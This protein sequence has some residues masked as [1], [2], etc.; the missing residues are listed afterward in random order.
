MAR[1]VSS[2]GDTAVIVGA[3]SGAFTGAAIAP[4]ELFN[5][6]ALYGKIPLLTTTALRLTLVRFVVGMVGF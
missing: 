5:E 2:F 1:R 3:M 4:T 6:T